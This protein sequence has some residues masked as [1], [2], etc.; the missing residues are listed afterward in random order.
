MLIIQGTL[1][2]YLQ[3]LIDT[4]S[5]VSQFV[6]TTCDLRKAISVL[7]CNSTCIIVLYS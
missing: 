4:I 1:T 5:I 6:S 3:M 2:C 7:Y